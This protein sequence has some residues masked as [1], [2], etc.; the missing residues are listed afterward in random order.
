VLVPLVG[1]NNA[2][3]FAQRLDLNL[4]VRH[5]RYND[6]GETTNPKFGVNWTP[7]Q[8]LT[9]RGSY[10]TSLR[11]PTFAELYG[12]SYNLYAQNYTDPTIPGIRQGVAL[13][14]G[15]ADLK[16]EEATT[17]TIGFDYTPSALSGA[18]FSGTY[19]DIEY[20][21]QVAA[22]LSNL[23]IL[24]LESEFNGTGIITRGADAAAIVA[25]LINDGVAYATPPASNPIT[26]FVDGRTFNL[27]RSLMSGFDFEASYVFGFAGG[28]LTAALNGTWLTN[29]ESSIT[30]NGTLVDRLDTI[31]NPHDFRMR[32]SLAWEYG[33]LRLYGVVNYIGGYDNDLLATPQDVDPWVTVDTN[34]TYMFGD[35]ETGLQF[36]V[37]VRNL[38]DEDP[39]YVNIAPNNNGSGGYDASAANPTGRVVGVSLRKRF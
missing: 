27:G 28:D 39:P 31:F 23:N 4:A 25:D 11:A 36:G 29:Y 24:S 12:N 5:D 1:E 9:I 6:V 17:Y 14:G 30:P 7:V 20:E 18:R 10:G 21:G 33:A 22:Y 26:L 3:P 37:D 38:F 35:P 13:S 19:F 16:P 32:T 34:V 15:N 2:M 8:D